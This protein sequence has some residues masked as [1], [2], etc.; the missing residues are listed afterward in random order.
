MI[1]K[2]KVI[3]NWGHAGFIKVPSP[4]WAPG[5]PWTD[6][7]APK[8]AKMEHPIWICKDF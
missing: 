8:H 6:S 4:G 3:T 5:R 7:K 1:N 2:F